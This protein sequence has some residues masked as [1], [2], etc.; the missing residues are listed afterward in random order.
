MFGDWPT[1]GSIAYRPTFRAQIIPRHEGRNGNNNAL[2]Y[3]LPE[4][5]KPVDSI[6][7]RLKSIQID[8]GMGGLLKLRPVDDQLWHGLHA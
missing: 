7:D 4:V 5:Q 1:Q 2:G 8:N 3:R 6:F